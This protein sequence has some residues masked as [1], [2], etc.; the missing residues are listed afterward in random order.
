MIKD[1]NSKP[2][3]KKHQRGWHMMSPKKETQAVWEQRFC[4][5][6]RPMSPPAQPGHMAK[7]VP[8]GRVKEIF[9]ARK[10]R[11][12]Q[13]ARNWFD[14]LDPK[15]VDSF[16]ELSQ[17]FLEEFSPQKKV[18]LR[19]PGLHN[20]T[21]EVFAQVG[22]VDKIGSEGGTDQKSSE[23]TWGRSPKKQN[24][25]KFCD[26]HGDRGHN[27]NDCY[28]LKRRIEEE[29]ASR[30]LAHL[31]K[32]IRQGNQQNRGHV[33]G[34]V[35]VINMIIT[36]RGHKRPYEAGRS[37]LMEEIAFPLMEE[38]Y[39]KSCMSTALRTLMPVSGQEKESATH[40]C[41]VSLTLQRDN[42]KYG[43]EKPQGRR[44]HYNSIYDQVSNTKWSGHNPNQ[45]QAILRN[46]NMVDQRLGK[47]PMVDKEIREHVVVRENAVVWN[48][49]LDQ[50]VIISDRLSFGWCIREALERTGH[51][52]KGMETILGKRSEQGRFGHRNDPNKSGQKG[53]LICDLFDFHAF[54]ESMD[55]EALLVGLVSFSGKGMKDFYIFVSFKELVDQVKGSGLAT[56][57]LEFLNQE[58]PVGIKIRPSTETES[59]SLGRNTTG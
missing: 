36:G 44:F 8:L 59:K 18:Q 57:K 21:K 22:L 23:G 19:L 9:L 35:K 53:K 49:Y 25:S 39:R 16:E 34:S 33:K 47:G 3:Q 50:P 45:E 7:S 13:K 43:H 29:V 46:I 28:Y 37:G 5:N 58:V 48:E 4:P 24:L 15:T 55:H 42:G 2:K 54:E 26:Y 11:H 20:V 14:D 12:Y 32:D 6:D 41:K 51:D 56:I 17:K 27:T 31:V 38:V 30:K 40:L 52:T 1:T 10:R